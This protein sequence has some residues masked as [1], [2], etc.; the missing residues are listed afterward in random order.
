MQSITQ[1]IDQTAT[2][3]AVEVNGLAFT[4]L[5]KARGIAISMDSEGAWRDNAF[6]ERLWRPVKYEEVYL[7]AY[8]SVAEAR[9]WIGRYLAFFNEKRPHSSRDRQTPDE[10]YFNNRP[11][12]AAA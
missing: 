8:D 1:D 2:A 3:G 6:V 7:R 5:L 11:R 12:A 4:G 9:A 10:A